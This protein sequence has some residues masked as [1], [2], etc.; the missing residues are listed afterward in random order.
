M[1]CMVRV[2]VAAAQIRLISIS[3]MCPSSHQAHRHPWL[4]PRQSLIQSLRLNRKKPR[5]QL[6]KITQHHLK[7]E[8][9]QLALQEIKRLSPSTCPNN[10]KCKSSIHHRC[11]KKDLSNRKMKL[12]IQIRPKAPEFKGSYP[13]RK[14]DEVEQQA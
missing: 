3:T 14:K 12:P 5:T 7:N 13:S 11:S 6:K 2:K 4:L 10:T 1:P 9:S 8:K